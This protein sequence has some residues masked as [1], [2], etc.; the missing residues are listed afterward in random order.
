MDEEQ[1]KKGKG[2]KLLKLFLILFLLLVLIIGGFVL[3]IYLR[4][5]DT[6]T[7]NEKYGL[8]NLPVI[9]QYFVKPAPKEED[10]ENKPVEDVKPKADDKKDDKKKKV[11]LT[12]KEIEAQMKEREAAEKKRVTKI[13]KLYDNMKPEDA[14]ADLEPLND[15]VVVLILQRMEEGNAANVLSAMTPDRAARITQLMY[16]GTKKNVTVPSDLAAQAGGG[17]DSTS[18]GDMGDAAASGEGA[19]Q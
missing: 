6:Q 5:F 2:K 18:S 10:M 19:A 4:I 8:Y 3:G 7:I 13:A 11:T 16:E 17:Q 9:G 15:D 14:A 12:K 1:E